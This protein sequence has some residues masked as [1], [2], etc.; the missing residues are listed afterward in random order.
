MH[1]SCTA[2]DPLELV[3]DYKKNVYTGFSAPGGARNPPGM[4]L[5]FYK[6]VKLY[7]LLNVLFS[8]GILLIFKCFLGSEGLPGLPGMGPEDSPMGSPHP[9]G[10]DMMGIWE[11]QAAISRAT[12]THFWGWLARTPPILRPDSESA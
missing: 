5:T 11:I 7:F 1:P 10:P 12:L 9:L 6:S 3:G 4:V 8:S 2:D